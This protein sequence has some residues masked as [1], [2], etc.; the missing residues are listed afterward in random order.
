MWIC[1]FT[2]AF[3]FRRVV[4]PISGIQ[5]LCT[6][7]ILRLYREFQ[8]RVNG[9]REAIA[10]IPCASGCDVP[11]V[12]S[13]FPNGYRASFVKL[14]LGT[15]T[16]R[17]ANDYNIVPRYSQLNL[18]EFTEIQPVTVRLHHIARLWF[19]NLRKS[20]GNPTRNL[21]VRTVKKKVN[22]FLFVHK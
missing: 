11:Y 22:K 18:I 19:W 4:L 10:Y 1:L 5:T 6:G 13:F 3:V 8:R 16:S 17:F 12:T 14:R 20:W 2:E 21:T 7:I 9:I 15:P